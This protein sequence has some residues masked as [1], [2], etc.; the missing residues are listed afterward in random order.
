MKVIPLWILL[1][2]L[3]GFVIGKKVYQSSVKVEVR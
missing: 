3:V 2:A 1:G